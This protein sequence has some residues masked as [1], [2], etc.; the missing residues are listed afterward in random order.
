M[1]I[2]DDVFGDLFL[3]IGPKTRGQ[4]RLARLIRD[5]ERLPGRIDAFKFVYRS[6][7]ADDHYV[8]VTVRGAQG[9]FRAGV[10]QQLSPHPEY[11]TLGTEVLVIHLDGQ[12]AVDWPE[13]L[14]RMGVA[15]PGD[16]AVLA[17]KTLKEPL[18]PGIDDGRL[19]TKRLERGH[20]TTAELLQFVPHE[21]MGMPTQNWHLDLDLAEGGHVHVKR[22]FVPPY[23]QYLLVTGAVLPVAVDA[24][25]P[26]KVYVDWPQAAEAAAGP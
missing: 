14:R 4:R 6:D 25:K 8:G 7:S 20:R 15:T 19:D 21:P 3:G 18:P 12:V 22:A 9:E 1:G 13:T 5:G 26:D 10:R 2:L 23:A 17:G 11:G 24:K 16:P